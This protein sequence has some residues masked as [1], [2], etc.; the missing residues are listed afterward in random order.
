M[1]WY[2]TILFVFLVDTYSC[3]TLFP[4]LCK[5]FSIKRSRTS[6]AI[7]ACIEPICATTG[8]HQYALCWYT[9]KPSRHDSNAACV[10]SMCPRLT[11]LELDPLFSILNSKRNIKSSKCL[12]DQYVMSDLFQYILTKQNVLAPL[13]QYVLTIN[14]RHLF[15]AIRIGRPVPH[16]ESAAIRIGCTNICPRVQYD[17][18]GLYLVVYIVWFFYTSTF[19]DGPSS[20]GSSPLSLATL[21]VSFI[22]EA[23]RVQ[24]Y[25]NSPAVVS[26]LPRAI[27]S[28]TLFTESKYCQ[29]RNSQ[30]ASFRTQ[31]ARKRRLRVRVMVK[32]F[33]YT[34]LYI[35]FFTKKHYSVTV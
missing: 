23:E 28:C 13:K 16:P 11:P 25:R 2:P 35:L 19:L 14:I 18:Q 27:L 3:S 6:G 10:W 31:R 29:E 22:R 12:G 4:L 8:S 34:S 33:H 5:T 15:R 7:R 24:H 32:L 17:L 26:D 30:Y 1:H 9:N 20:C 21:A